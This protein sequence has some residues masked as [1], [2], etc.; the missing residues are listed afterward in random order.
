MD[1]VLFTPY[2]PFRSKTRFEIDESETAAKRQVDQ[3]QRTIRNIHCTYD[4]EVVWHENPFVWCPAI[5]EFDRLFA[6][7]LAGFHEGQKLTKNLGW[8]SAVD[9]LDYKH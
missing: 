7:S 1:S 2:F 3:S 9:L 8:I 6:T 4:V 5:C